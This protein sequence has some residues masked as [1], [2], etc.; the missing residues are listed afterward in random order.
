MPSRRCSLGGVRAPALCTDMPGPELVF[1]LRGG[2]AGW[3]VRLPAEV[4]GR[5]FMFEPH[6]CQERRENGFAKAC[7]PRPPIHLPS[8]SPSRAPLSPAA[9]RTIITGLLHC[10]GCAQGLCGAPDNWLRA[11][12]R[13]GDGAGGGGRASRACSWLQQRRGRRERRRLGELFKTARCGGAR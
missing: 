12:S 3:K 13:V 6:R 11:R 9:H 4:D 10:C 2:G 1:G 8:L 7:D 5:S